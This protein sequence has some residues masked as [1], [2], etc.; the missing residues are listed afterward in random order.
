MGE[1]IGDHSFLKMVTMATMNPP[2]APT[3]T[4]GPAKL[5]S[6]VCMKEFHVHAA[7]ATAH[8]S[9]MPVLLTVPLSDMRAEASTRFPPYWLCAKLLKVFWLS[10]GFEVL[11]NAMGCLRFA[12]QG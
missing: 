10:A 9:R 12:K 11:N 2:N 7:V 4:A 6:C 8:S 5:R 3:S 1:V